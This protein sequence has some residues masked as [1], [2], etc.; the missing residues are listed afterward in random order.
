MSTPSPIDLR[1]RTR[2][3]EDAVKASRLDQLE[4]DED[5]RFIMSSAPGRR[6]VW[7]W[8]EEAGVYRSSFTGNSTTFFNEGMRNMGL[9]LLGHVHA[10]CPDQYAIMVK[11]S[12]Q[13]KKDKD[14][15]T[16]SHRRHT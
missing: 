2:L 6:F 10:V 5:L 13:T 15:N 3:K 9:A 1:E 8:L 16:E 11:E 4:A 12:Q 7:R 14:G